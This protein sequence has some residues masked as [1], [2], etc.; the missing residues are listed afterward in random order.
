[1][2]LAGI[3]TLVTATVGGGV[4]YLS[5]SKGKN[6]VKVFANI[7]TGSSPD[8]NIQSA[9]D[10]IIK[11]VNAQGESIEWLRSELEI[12][13]QHLENARDALKKRDDELQME[14]G[15]LKSRITELETQVNA[16]QDELNRRKKYT[17]KDYRSE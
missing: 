14:N 3:I 2:E 9:L 13:K 12:T 17:R 15:K 11:V 5:T 1:M 7:F 4:A 10:N 16:L 8:E 6:A